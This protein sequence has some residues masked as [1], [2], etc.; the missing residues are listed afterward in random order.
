MPRYKQLTAFKLAYRE[1]LK[2]I[3][4]LILKDIKDIK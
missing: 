2:S 4:D 1:H 3:G